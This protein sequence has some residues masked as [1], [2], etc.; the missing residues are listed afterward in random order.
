MLQFLATFSVAL[1]LHLHASPHRNEKWA[2]ESW[3][4]CDYHSQGSHTRWKTMK[5][6]GI[7]KYFSRALKSLE[8]PPKIPKGLE[9]VLNFLIIWILLLMVL[10]KINNCVKNTTNI[11]WCYLFWLNIGLEIYHLGLEKVWKKV[12]N[13]VYKI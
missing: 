3:L 6:Y 10:N 2:T 12:L 5:R 13:F 8:F 4:S 7:S 11:F 1:R 9:K